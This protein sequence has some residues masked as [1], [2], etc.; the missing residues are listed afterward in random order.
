VASTGSS[1][2][3][4]PNPVGMTFTVPGN[5]AFKI[6]INDTNAI[7]VSACASP[8]TFQLGGGTF[9]CSPTT[10]CYPNCDHSTTNPC[11]TV[12]DFGCFLNAF[13]AGDT[14]ANCDG[15]TQIPVLT[16]QDFGCFLNSF[17]AGCGTNC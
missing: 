3:I 12:Q 15:S 2:G 13:A 10:G 14:Y 7:G 16:V 6:V 17:A 11:L 4:P 5:T 8:Y 9:N 1:T